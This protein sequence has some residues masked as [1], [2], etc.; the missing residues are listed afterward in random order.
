MFTGTCEVTI[1]LVTVVLGLFALC[2]YFGRLAWGLSLLYFFSM[3]WIYTIKQEHLVQ[4]FG[5]NA[6]VWFGAFAAGLLIVV[7]TIRTM[8]PDQHHH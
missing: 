6:L 2:L 1:D 3:F 5:D 8:L 4:T 7:H